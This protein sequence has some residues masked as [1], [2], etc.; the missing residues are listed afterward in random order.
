M[1]LS[2]CLA[3]EKARLISPLQLAYIGDSVHTLMT[4]ARLMR[5]ERRMSDMHRLATACVNAAAQARALARL[6]PFLTEEEAEMV[7]RGRNAHAHHTLP[8]AATAED[9]AAATAL[10][11][12]YGYLFMCGRTARLAEIDDICCREEESPCP[13]K[14]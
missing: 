7:R 5:V 1:S 8:K 6:L 2:P 12:L 4:R 9:Y 14:V 3:P 10:E 11:T 13:K